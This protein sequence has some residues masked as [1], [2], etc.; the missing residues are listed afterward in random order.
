MQASRDQH[1]LQKSPRI[2]VGLTATEHAELQA[3]AEANHISMAWVG[4]QAILEFLEKYRGDATQL[5]LK[6][7]RGKG[8]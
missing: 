3:I 7:T 2:S 4:R 5:P 8:Q 6:L 1:S